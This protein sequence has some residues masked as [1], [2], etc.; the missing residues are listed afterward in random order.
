[1]KYFIAEK[2]TGEIFPAIMIGGVLTDSR[3]GYDATA[4]KWTECTEEE[5]NA[6]CD[7]LGIE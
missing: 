4:D 5:W 2:I 3:T 1:M 6:L 7:K